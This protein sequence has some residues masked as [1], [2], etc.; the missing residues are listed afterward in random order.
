MSGDRN[1][2]YFHRVSKIRAA[3]KSISLLQDGDD[4][5]TD[6]TAIE[7]HILSY[8]QAIFSMDNNCAQNTMVDE[9]IPLIVSDI[10]NNILISVPSHEEIRAA[11]FALN[12]DGAPGP[13]GFGGHFYQSFWDIVGI[14]VVH[15]VQEIFLGGSLPPNINSN[16]IVLI[17]KVPGAKTMGDYR[18]IALAK[19]KFKIVTKI[20]ADRLACITSRIIS[21]E[22]R[23]FVRDRNISECIIIASEAINLLDKKQYG[24]NLALK[25]DIS[26]A[27]D[28]LDWNF[29]IAVLHNFGFST[30]F[31]NW[32][33]T[34]LQSARLSILV[35][36]KA[37]GFFSC[38][39]GVRQGDPL[40]PLLFCLAEEVLSRALSASAH[41]GR[42][43][44]MSLCRGYVLP[45]HVLYADDILI[46][47]TGLKSNVRELLRIFKRYSEVSGQLI[48]NAKSRFFTGAMS[49]SCTIMIA[50]L[51]GFSVGTVPF[52][53]LGCPIFKG[54]PKVI[55][56]RMITDRIKNKLATWKGRILSIMGRVQLVKSIIHGM[57]V[58]SFHVYLWPRRLLRLLDTWIKNFIW[59]GDVLTRKVCTVSWQVLCRTWE[60]GGLDIRP[61]RLINESLILK[62]SW[63]LIAHDKQWATLFK[64]RYFLNGRPSTRYFQT[65]VWSGIKSHIGKVL[66]NSLWIVGTGNKIHFWIDNWL[67]DPLVDL[68]HIDVDFHGHMKGMVSEVIENGS[69]NIPAP[70][71]DFG[72]IKARLDA[73]VLPRT[74]LEDVLVWQHSSDGILHSKHASAFLRPS[75]QVLPW[76]ASIWRA[77]VPPSHSFIFL[78]LYHS[79]VPTDENLRSRG[80][81]VVSVCSLCLK[82]DESSEHLFLRCPFASRLWGWIGGK[83][84]CVIDS[85][86]VSTLLDCRP[87]RCSSQVSD[88]FLAAILHIV[89]TIW[90]ARNAVRFSDVT[91][92]V[93]AA[94]IRIHS[95]IALSGN[96]SNGKCLHSDFAL[97]DSFAVSPNCRRVKDIVSGCFGTI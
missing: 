63:D 82:T 23:G 35:N 28:T 5:I 61:T 49:G 4:D 12:A 51:L 43:I 36:G 20:M 80:C 65:S 92:T 46:F 89:H 40:S 91:P 9:T 69:W 74:Q 1:T 8:F 48:N 39:R 19:F 2:A 88:I 81:I 33:L 50:N 55:H 64:Q 37:V 14:D 6:P 45:T 57:I 75:S 66:N 27:F 11:V 87:A 34:I 15:S 41:R 24:G 21:T 18:P 17:P 62:L 26:K 52:Q 29:L 85:S 32:I 94:K 70:I 16:M 54:K 97:L 30:I 72:D 73:L 53:Y 42:L 71:T 84:N 58:Y 67:G 44:P 90:W 38:S 10:E 68:M 22:Q 7:L 59:S 77:A 56:F 13:D 95:S 96:I 83:L 78:R 60:E 47:C 76:A 93:H 86:S 31:I 3:T 79:K 25:V